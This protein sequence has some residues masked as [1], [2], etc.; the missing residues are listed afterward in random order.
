MEKSMRQPL[1]KKKT[2]YVLGRVLLY[3]VLTVIGMLMFLPFYWSMVSSVR[4]NIE[5]I[6]G[7]NL[8]PKHWTFEHYINLFKDVPIG[9]S[10]LNTL[11]VT[12]MGMFTNLF[13]CSLC[14]YAFAKFKFRG[15]KA[16]ESVFLL[17]MMIPGV[18]LIVPQFIIT[19]KLGLH[20]TYTGA[21]AP[22]A[23]GLFGIFFMKQFF[24]SLPNDIGEAARVDG[25][26]ELTIFVRLYLPIA[27]A[28]LIT[29]G[30]FTFNAYW[31]SFMW[32]NLVLSQEKQVIT[33]VLR[34]YTI[35]YSDNMGPLMSGAI[36]SVIPVFIVYVAGQKYFV[37]NMVF[38]GLKG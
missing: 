1:W 35:K 30:I 23:I 4:P 6:V 28:G 31:N 2:L 16:V 5:S 11:C 14:A 21:V 17:S 36:I 18:V 34:D 24:Q 3:F 13:F 9:R 27:T 20:G 15:K 38:S 32:P 10:F 12:A 25:A 33:V 29:L 7:V 26:G 37:N 22:G 19:F 8:F